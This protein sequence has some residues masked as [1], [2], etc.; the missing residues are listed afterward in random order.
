MSRRGKDFTQDPVKQA[1]LRDI[2]RRQAE[3]KAATL[4]WIMGDPRGR[5]FMYEL[6]FDICGIMNLYPGQDSGLYRHEGRREVGFR[7][8]QKLQH[9]QADNYVKMIT[10]HVVEQDNDRKLREAALQPS[11]HD[12]GD[13]R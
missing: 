5:Q 1:K 11:A 3:Q 2:E 6:I 9:E 7:L 13:E 12:Q 8:T 10:E 4:R